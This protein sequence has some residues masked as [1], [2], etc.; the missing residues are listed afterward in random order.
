[1]RI[2][3]TGGAGF[4]GSHTVDRLLQRGH[5]VRV[6][7]SLEKP[8]H[9][10]G[11]PR[12]LS[13]DVEFIEASILDR[14][15]FARALAGVDAVFHLAAYQDYLTDFSRFF[16]VNAAGTALLYEL[17]VAG[18]LPVSKVV[19]ASSQAVY[20]EGKYACVVDGVQYPPQRPESALRRGAWE[21]PCPVCGEP[22]EPLWT[23]DARVNPHNPYA[24]SKR[25]QEEVALQLGRR[26]AIP[27]VAMRYSIVQGP[28]QSFFNAYS[29]A[30]RI[31]AVRLLN[32]EPA[33]LY[34]DGQQLRDYVWVG[35]VAAANM[36]VLEDT[37][38]DYRTF[39]VGSGRRVTVRGLE[40][41]IRRAVGSGLEPVVTGD[42]RFGDTRHVV[43][44]IAPLVSLGW[45]PTLSQREI[46]EA[47]VAWAAEQ[48][49]ARD[50]YRGAETHMRETG[51]LRRV[52]A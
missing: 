5:A 26:Y 50:A 29:G 49:A 3:V 2:L 39:N 28:R 31:F 38:A 15:A 6:I 20:G 21:L 1:M 8:V 11:R 17:I 41:E 24:M 7:D 45:S 16:H 42:Y 46:A 40:A 25:A 9:A 52:T 23:D 19:V 47:Y 22:L 34:E 4:I 43:S 48:P 37:R 18:G 44:D 10:A 51:V 30:C 35:D 12:W 13:D 14:E 27:T 36:L 33:V 32:G